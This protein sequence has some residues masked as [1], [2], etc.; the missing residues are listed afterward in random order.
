MTQVFILQRGKL[1]APKIT[2]RKEEKKW[3]EEGRQKRESRKEQKV[4]SWALGDVIPPNLGC[5]E[6]SCKRYYAFRYW[7]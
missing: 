5:P 7:E 2:E 3:K 1:G 4:E 6:V